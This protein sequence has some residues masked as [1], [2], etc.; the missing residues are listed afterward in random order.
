MNLAGVRYYGADYRFHY[1]DI[2][3]EDGFIVQITKR[4][5]DAP[6]GCDTVVPGMVD[7][8]LHGNSGKDFSDGDYDGLKTIA[9]YLARHGTTSFSATSM[10][11]PE[12]VIEKACR[13]AV[14]M[15]DEAPKGCARLRGMTMEGPFFSEAKKGAQA[16]AHLRLPDINMLRRLQAEA[17]GLIR[18]VCVAPELEGALP[19]IR[20]AAGE[21]YIVSAAHTGANYDEAVR[22]FEAGISHVTHLFN[23][24]PPL[25]HREPGVIGAAA[26]RPNVSAELIGDGVHVHASAVRA[27][28]KLFGPERMCLVSDA[29]P[30]AGLPEGA[31]AMLG[32]QRVTIKGGRAVL[33]SGTL[34]GSITALYDCVRSVIGMG[35]PAEYALRCATANPAKVIGAGDIGVIAEGKRADFLI[36][37]EDWA[38]KEV[39]IAGNSIERA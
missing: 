20:E 33:D 3:V 14:R 16:A 18:I 39:Y 13:N 35:I 4:D 26:E 1:G 29:I 11:L 5:E 6:A 7:I 22:G 25:L 24:M 30:A 19:F 12:G 27:A 9:G 32:G 38:L 21:G 15:R 34:A 28:F 36:C 31:T 2:R 8:H 37:G 10:T 23:A 17:D